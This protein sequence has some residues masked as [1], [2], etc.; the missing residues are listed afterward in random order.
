ME[1]TDRSELTERF[2]QMVYML[3]QVN[4]Q[5]NQF[6]HIKN[7]QKWQHGMHVSKMSGVSGDQL[8]FLTIPNVSA[9]ISVRN[10]FE[11]SQTSQFQRGY[12]LSV[13]S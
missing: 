11:S 2:D 6:K 4:K 3:E 8:F 7:D 13:L 1:V 5:E 12:C 10:F 9:K